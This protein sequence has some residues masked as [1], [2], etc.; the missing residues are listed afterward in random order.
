MAE[1]SEGG[2]F[3]EDTYASARELTAERFSSPFI[4]TFVASWLLF[5]YK[6]IILVLTDSS[7]KFSVA[8]KLNFIQNYLHNSS[9][10][11]PNISHPILLN[12]FLWP[13]LA[14]G[15]YT[16]IYP[17]A[18]F[19]ITKFTLNRKVA[20]RNMRIEKEEDVFY[21]FKDVQKIYIKHA[22]DEKNSRDRI[23]RAEITEAQ[24]SAVI[25]DL[26]EKLNEVANKKDSKTP[27]ELKSEFSDVDTKLDLVKAYI[28]MDDIDGAKE[29]LNETMLDADANQR[30]RAKRLINKIEKEMPSSNKDSSKTKQASEITPDEIDI[31]N[32]LGEAND[33]FVD[34]V[35][36][37]DIFQMK[38]KTATDVKI[39]LDNLTTKAFIKRD[40][41]SGVGGY[42]SQLT[43]EELVGRINKV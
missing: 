27:V 37:T 34:W 12:G 18:D 10:A 30:R 8:N 4:F 36:D 2:N 5:N 29:L 21:R 40:Y 17:F 3:L 38:G 19:Y 43:V 20:I 24:Q 28:Q 11:I 25:K 16:F 32:V 42:C 1:N 23:E 13:L 15:F 41:K 33:K 26:Q 31:I 9:F 22:R 7:E 39:A 35:L 14:A 6:V